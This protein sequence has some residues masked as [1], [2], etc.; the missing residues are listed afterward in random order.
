MHIIFLLVVTVLTSLISGFYIYPPLLETLDDLFPKTVFSPA[1]AASPTPA[2]SAGP[3]PTD[4][5]FSVRLNEILAEDPSR[6]VL[7][8]SDADIPSAPDEADASTESA[9]IPDGISPVSPASDSPAVS[10]TPTGSVTPVPSSLPYHTDSPTHLPSPTPA[11][12]SRTD[13]TPTGMPP[14]PAPAYPS[15]VPTVILPENGMENGLNAGVLFA[16]VNDY[17]K[18]SGLPPLL[19]DGTT[20]AIASARAPQV[21]GEIFVSGNMHAGLKAMHLPYW[22]TETIIYIDTEQAAVEWW[23]ADAGHRNVLLG[24]YRNSCAACAGFGCSQVFT[25][26]LPK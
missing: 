14:T 5:P 4:I 20:C 25:S 12:T 18:S 26:Y 13:V 10:F 6:D 11:P 3:V 8:E 19:T 15:P 17:R 22:I 7:A 24:N 2:P 21:F 23:I 1:V 9:G 16:L